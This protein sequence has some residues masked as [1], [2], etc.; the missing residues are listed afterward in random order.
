MFSSGCFTFLQSKVKQRNPSSSSMMKALS[1]VEWTEWNPNLEI[2]TYRNVSCGPSQ[3]TLKR[4]C[5][6][7]LLYY[8]CLFLSWFFFRKLIKT[9][10]LLKKMLFYPSCNLKNIAILLFFTCVYFSSSKLVSFFFSSSFYLSCK[11]FW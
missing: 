2:S 9:R 4:L 3:K 6:N 5:A 1:K 11:S 7:V 8:L 10:Y